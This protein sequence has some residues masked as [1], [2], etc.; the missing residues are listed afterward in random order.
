MKLQ[1]SEEVMVFE[2]VPVDSIVG[3]VPDEIQRVWKSDMF[4]VRYYT[5]NGIERLSVDY[6]VPEMNEYIDNISWQVLQDIKTAVG[7]G[8]RVA[9][10]LYP[11]DDK[12][13]PGIAMRHLWLVK[14][15]ETI[16]TGL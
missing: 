5:K 15:N 2:E 7:F 8:H 1:V 4:L 6:T 10:E 9:I 11:P 12:V 3:G 14:D 16:P 13:I